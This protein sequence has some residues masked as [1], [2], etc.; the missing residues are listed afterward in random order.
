MPP[1]ATDALMDTSGPPPAWHAA[2][3]EAAETTMRTRAVPGLLVAR[4][5]GDDPP[6]YLAVGG[7]AG[8]RPLA[9]DTLFPVASITKLATAH[10]THTMYDWWPRLAAVGRAVLGGGT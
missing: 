8:G 7:D 9:P 6:E 10:G 2:A 1:A 5:H 4:V 3:R